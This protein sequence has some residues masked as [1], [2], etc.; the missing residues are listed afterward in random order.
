[1][2]VGSTSHLSILC[3]ADDVVLIAKGPNPIKKM[4]TDLKKAALARGLKV[5]SGNTKVLTNE[6][7]V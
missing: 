6:I 3:F 2:S 4:L 1:M 5:H 7:E